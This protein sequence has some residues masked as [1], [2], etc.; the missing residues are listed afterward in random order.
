MFGKICVVF[1]AVLSVAC[2]PSGG[3]QM[4]DT[5]PAHRTDS[6]SPMHGECPP[7]FKT[8]DERLAAGVP[9]VFGTVES[10][11]FEDERII[12]LPDPENAYDFSDYVLSDEEC[13]KHFIRPAVVL[14]L[15]VE[16]SIY[17]DLKGQVVTAWFDGVAWDSDVTA[18]PVYNSREDAWY[19]S[20]GNDYFKPG[21]SLGMFA[22][23]THE[24]MLIVSRD[25]L[26]SVDEEGRVL[27]DA[28]NP[29]GCLEGTLVG[30]DLATLM[31]QAQSIRNEH[32]GPIYKTQFVMGSYCRPYEFVE[33]TE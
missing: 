18:M 33:A 30:R 29:D 2:S 19:W 6:G 27:T 9:L 24:D 21:T 8:M 15:R 16:D 25:S 7:R 5:F 14:Q 32:P 31:E 22:S 11:H 1:C 23:Q 17:P 10:M 13:P 12:H 20:D 28:G 4:G 3:R 26:F